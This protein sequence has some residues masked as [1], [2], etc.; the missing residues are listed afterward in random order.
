MNTMSLKLQHPL[1]LVC[2][3]PQSFTYPFCYEPHK[4]CEE[5]AQKVQSYI[6]SSG[7][8]HG[9]KGGKMFGV[10]VVKEADRLSFLAAYS[11]LL[12]GRNDWSYFVPPIFDAQCPDGHFKQ[13]ER[14]ISA[15]NAEIASIEKSADYQ[16][17]LDAFSEMQSTADHEL[18]QMKTQVAIA[19]K[20][21]DERRAHAVLH[22]VPISE[23]E[24]REMVRESQHM[25]AE[26][27]R[28]SKRL[29]EQLD[30][31]HSDVEAFESRIKSLES[32]RRK[33][34]DDLQRWLFSQYRVLNALGEERNLIQ[35][36]D[37]YAHSQP[38][39]GAGDCCA[40]KLLQYAYS[41]HLQPVC[42]AEFWWGESPQGEI[43]HHLHYYPAC[44]SKCLPIL[45][46]MLQGL[47]VDPNPL[48]QRA[49][50]NMKIIYEDET[51]AVVDKPAGMLSVP[52]KEALPSV[53]DAMRK[54]WHL[55]S[56]SPVM[57]HRLDKDTSGLLI[58]ARTPEAY[59][60]LQRQFAAHAVTKRYEAILDGEPQLKEGRITLPLCPDITDRPRQC[61]NQEHGK[62]AVTDFHVVAT[63][64]TPQ[65]THTLVWLYPHTGRTHQLRVHCAHKDGLQCP[66][67]GD[68]LYGR[69]TKSERMWLQA[70]EISFR[71]PLNGKQMHFKLA[72][73]KC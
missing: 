36:F 14:Q 6:E 66:I 45:T 18:M 39:A 52:G 50:H 68:P 63:N 3:P 17:A 57:P 42:M 46:F 37:S 25:K 34:S 21:R 44:R 7:V 56:D 53:E 62:S 55:P 35:V 28:L 69:G 49:E 32:L 31:A 72:S 54:R 59:V 60:D 38:P 23:A 13:T 4:L 71:H 29:R 51:L 58:V 8:M 65:G 1:S 43:R 20:H 19:K 61:V 24:E 73:L 12:S 30:H 10:L 2:N 11:G 47:Q 26:L 64:H 67:L 5:A 41:H 15:I 40:P 33:M 48:A 16:S 70:T 22:A 9:E 27:H